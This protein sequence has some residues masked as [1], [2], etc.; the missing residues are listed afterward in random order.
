VVVQVRFAEWTEDGHLRHATTFLGF[1]EDK[2][3]AEMR[4]ED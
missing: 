3:A 1:R 4:R 2:A